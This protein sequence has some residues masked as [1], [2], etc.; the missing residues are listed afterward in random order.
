MCGLT[1]AEGCID[2]QW[3]PEFAD[4]TRMIFSRSH[5]PNFAF[6]QAHIPKKLLQGPWTADKI[7]FLRFL[8]WL[9]SMPVDWKDSEV[10]EIA[11]KGRKQAMLAR[12]LEAV[13]LFNHNRRL[14]RVADLGCVRY[15]VITAGCDR[16]IVFDTL[17]AA[18][19]CTGLSEPWK[20]T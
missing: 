12:N 13:E 10:R 11:I 5:L 9:T 7:Q 18:N 4:A 1:P 14:G 2:T 17:C 19:I 6:V 15:A 16:S 3:P 8:L 20:C